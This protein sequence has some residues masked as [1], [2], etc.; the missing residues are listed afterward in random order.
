M[1]ISF[2]QILI[3]KEVVGFK[4]IFKEIGNC[5]GRAIFSKSQIANS[6][7]SKADKHLAICDRR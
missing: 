1:F 7:L 5:I 3:E 2:T 6:K 4:V